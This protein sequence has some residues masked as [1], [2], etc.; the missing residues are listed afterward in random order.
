MKVNFVPNDKVCGFFRAVQPVSFLNYAKVMYNF[1][2]KQKPDIT[3]LCRAV[4]QEIYDCMKNLQ[5]SGKKVFYEWDDYFFDISKYNPVGGYLDQ[6]K[7]M[8]GAF[9]HEVDGVICSTNYL[10]KLTKKHTKKPIYV[11]PNAINMAVYDKFVEK[12][13]AHDTVNIGYMGSA[14]HLEDIYGT[15]VWKAIVMILR[16]FANVRLVLKGWDFT[17]NKVFDG[18]RN[19]VIYYEGGDDYQLDMLKFDIG[20]APLKVTDFNKAKS[21][22]KFLEYSALKIPTIA[23]KIQPY[24]CMTHNKT[25]ILIENK[26]SYWYNNIKELIL[27]K[28]KRLELAQNAND[29]VRENFDAKNVAKKYTEVFKE[30]LDV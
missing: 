8:V 29:Y 21:N 14:T 27:N 22:L 6:F 4:H 7:A 28:D 30:V 13:E 1:D 9:L 11:I 16:E 19:K 12:K 25:G 23:T 18:L 20:L 10:A 15:Q 2:S 3:V 5:R 17:N 26:V 24:K